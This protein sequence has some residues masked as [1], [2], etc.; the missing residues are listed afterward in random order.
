MPCQQRCSGFCPQKNNPDREGA[1]KE[2]RQHKLP[3]FLTYPI[4][5][6]LKADLQSR[7]S[8]P[9]GVFRFHFPLTQQQCLYGICGI[10]S[11]VEH[12]MG[13][14]HNGHVHSLHPGKFPDGL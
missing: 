1:N 7:R 9:A 5:L 14:L 2:F 11:F 13:G 10:Q 4:V 6:S 8:K 3:E 12:R